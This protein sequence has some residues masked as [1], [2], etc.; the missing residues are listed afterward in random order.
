[1]NR[2]FASLTRPMLACVGALALAGCFAG[3]PPLPGGPQEVPPA[4]SMT[5]G[6]IH[7]CVFCGDDAVMRAQAQPAAG[8]DA[9]GA[10]QEP[11][12][13]AAGA[14]A[15][16]ADARP[17]GSPGGEPDLA[18]RLRDAE[19]FCERPCRGPEG[20]S[21]IG[22]GHR[23]TPA[24]ADALLEKDMADARAAA[25][26]IV[27]ESAWGGLTAPRRDALVEIA[28]MAGPTG[29]A[30]FREMLAALRAGDY[31]RAADE[32]TNSALTPAVRRDRIAALMRQ[33]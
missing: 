15:S 6:A 27:G 17:S 2:S 29:L 21:H 22:H 7:I 18:Q 14:G 25:E 13:P 32:I 1:M 19:G 10:G 24:E 28:F 23:I 4:P 33:G 11:S 20:A 8:A 16:G 9:A 30:R 5:T 3:M 31:A 26:R 12:Q